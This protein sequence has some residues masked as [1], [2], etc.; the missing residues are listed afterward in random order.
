MRRLR[1]DVRKRRWVVATTLAL[2]VA[3]T[4]MALVPRTE[5]NPSNELVSAGRIEASG[6]PID[7]EVGHAAPFVGDFDGDG[8]HDLLVGQ[9]GGVHNVPVGQFSQGILWVYRNQGTNAKPRLAAGT[10]FKAG[11][12]DG[13][14]PTG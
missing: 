7:T 5:P 8:V 2:F 3:G 10:K 11:K 6:N 12:D 1:I 4:L 13:R 9:F 14:V